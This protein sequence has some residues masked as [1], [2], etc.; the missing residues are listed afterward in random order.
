MKENWAW[1][2]VPRG[3]E[4]LRCSWIF[5]FVVVLWFFVFVCL[6]FSLK[7]GFFTLFLGSENYFILMNYVL[8]NFGMKEFTW[9]VEIMFSLYL[10]LIF[11]LNFF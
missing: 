4:W 9:R 5:V 11:I 7:V 10:S 3:L 2:F 1:A 8:L 6:P